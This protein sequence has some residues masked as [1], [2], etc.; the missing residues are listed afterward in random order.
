LAG[1]VF[2]RGEGLSALPSDRIEALGLLLVTAAFRLSTAAVFSRHDDLAREPTT[3]AS[4]MN[5]E[6]VSL[7]DSQP[8]MGDLLALAPQLRD[9]NDLW[10]AA[11]SLE[12]ALPALRAALEQK[13]G[14]PWLM[15][16]SG[17]TLFALY[18]SAA[19]AAEAGR[20]LVGSRLP[21]LESALI[22]A[23]DLVGPDPI[24]RH[25]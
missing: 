6:I 4:E 11:A 16:G 21:E 17:S 12:P 3:V 22:N 14:V 1:L 10:A 7:L 19:E 15:S 9:A 24:W 13:T 2:G 8:M 18:P 5:E 25:P 20:A 23:V